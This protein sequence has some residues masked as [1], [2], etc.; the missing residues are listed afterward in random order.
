[1]MAEIIMTYNEVDTSPLLKVLKV[2]RHIGNSR[3]LTKKEQV[4][5]GSRLESV[6]TEDK[7][8]EVEFSIA[9]QSIQTSFI[10]VITP[11]RTAESNTNHL[12]RE[13]AKLFNQN[14]PKKLK[15]SDDNVFYWAIV[16]DSAEIEDV[17]EWY[18]VGTVTF[19]ILD[20]V[21]HA[22]TDKTFSSVGNRL[23]ITNSGGDSVYP[24]LSFTSASN[25][26][27][28]SFV[29]GTDVFQIGKSTGEIIIN[30]GE[31]V[32]IDM[33]DG[34]I[35]VS[36]TKRIY[37]NFNSRRLSV[38]VGTFSIG[39]AVN[40]GASIPVVRAMINEVYV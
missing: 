11:S 25:L 39:I 1:M 5:R 3:R 19:T 40:S 38:G 9:S 2:K 22:L 13:I 8:I 36:K 35:I 18:A 6:Y 21:A 17:N 24:K 20:G 12:K 32:E 33:S 10:D 28:I 7:L 14:E 30:A 26:K 29:L 31:N 34:S 37:R 16:S 15:F 27:M 4:R 23:T